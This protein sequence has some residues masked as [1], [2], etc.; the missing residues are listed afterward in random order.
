MNSFFSGLG[1]LFQKAGSTAIDVIAAQKQA[2]IGIGSTNPNVNPAAAASANNS[3]SQQKAITPNYVPWI[4]GG[5]AVVAGV[6]LIVA[7]SRK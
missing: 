2:A 5:I 7:L 6:G 1:D 3:N 4:I